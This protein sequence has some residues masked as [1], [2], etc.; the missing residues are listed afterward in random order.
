[1]VI[2]MGSSIASCASGDGG[3]AMVGASLGHGEE[4]AGETDT[5]F[6]ETTSGSSVSE[7]GEAGEAG[8][9]GESGE[10]TTGGCDEP[11][12]WYRDADGDGHGDPEVV[13]DACEQPDGYVPEAGDCDDDD[14]TVHPGAAQPCGGPDKNCD[15][16]APPMCSSC[17]QMLEEDASA[18][19]GL[20]TI[21]PDGRSGE[22]P[23]VT[24]WC[25]MSTDGGGWTLVQRTVWN[26][27]QTSA[28]RTGFDDWHNL[29]IGNPSPGFGYRLQGEAWPHLST[30]HDHLL[31]HELRLAD[32]GTCDPLF[33]KGV[34]GVLTITDTTVS[35]TG[36]DSD[37]G[38]V[39]G[40]ELSTSDSGPSSNCVSGNMGVPWFYGSCCSTCPTYQGAYWNEPHPMIS[41]SHTVA[42]LQGNLESDVC[43][44]PVQLSL[45]G[46]SYRGVAVMEYYLR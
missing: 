35:L 42:D 29:S 39:S 28:L 5:S 22:L 31:R 30:A 45:N 20:Q 8:E 18:A 21:D 43:G 3:T 46:S 11:S 36:L 9:A 1:M 26:P 23:P 24:V 40:P 19:D 17:L 25:D 2:S 32:G 33:Y 15:G 4:T 27:A 6:G 14:P 37:A 13:Q 12:T 44:G 7:S 41:Y 34:D 38:M 16:E 10:G